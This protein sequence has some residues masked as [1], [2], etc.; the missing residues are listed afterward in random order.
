M[1]EERA[2]KKRVDEAAIN[3]KIR[4]QGKLAQ[5]RGAL[6]GNLYLLLIKYGN[7]DI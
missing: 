1:L 3:A 2:A 5:T 6:L 7:Y 4:N